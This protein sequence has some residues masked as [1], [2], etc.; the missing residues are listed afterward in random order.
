MIPKLLERKFLGF[1]AS[2]VLAVI[3]FLRDG[4]QDYKLW[5]DHVNRHF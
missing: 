1:K 2:V 5:R 3:L 4:F